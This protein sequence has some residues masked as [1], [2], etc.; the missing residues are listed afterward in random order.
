MSRTIPTSLFAALILAAAVAAP[1]SAQALQGRLIDDASGAPVAQA[2]VAV[3]DIRSRPVG[4]VLTDEAGAFTF[5][6]PATGRYVIRASRVGY[7]TVDTPP[8]DVLSTETLAVE[9]RI[10]AGVVPLAPLTV[11]AQRAPFAADGTLM[12][13]GYYTRKQQYEALGGRFLDREYL[14]TRNAFR[15]T[16]IFR[17]LP[18][19]R[20][21]AGPNRTNVITLRGGCEPAIFIDGAHVNRLQVEREARHPLSIRQ[22]G[23]G[24]GGGGAERDAAEQRREGDTPSIDQLVPPSSIAAIEVYQGNQI[25]AEYMTFQTRPCGVVVIWTGG[26]TA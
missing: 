15:T 6:L 10:A 21:S 22:S 19:V 2:Q 24:F 13:R 1:L 12:R 9:V 5:V 14:R 26:E 11:T 25:P 3:L 8:M 16:D 4:R 17:D 23:G 20:V 7:A 18:G